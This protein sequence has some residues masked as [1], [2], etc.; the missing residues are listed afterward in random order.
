M[1]IKLLLDT[2]ILVA[3]E[4][5]TLSLGE[6]VDPDDDVAIAVVTA[7]ELQVGVE[8]SDD[9]HRQQRRRF[10]QRVIDQFPVIDYTLPVALTHAKLAAS[11]SG[12]GLTRS[13]PD[14][15]IAA[16]ALASMRTLVTADAG[17]EGM[18]GLKTRLYRS[19]P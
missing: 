12:R 17:F 1:G 19:Q 14:L 18:P 4:R 13:Q 5:A 6:V 16:T 10:L 3:V 8:K 15:M 2:G 9:A 11:M 7:G